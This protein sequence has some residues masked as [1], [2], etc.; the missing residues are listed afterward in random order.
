[1]GASALRAGEAVFLKALLKHYGLGE[2]DYDLVISGP[3]RN[4]VSAMTARQIDGTVMIP[5]DSYLL[6]DAGIKR[7]AE[8]SEAV[9]EYEF[10]MLAVTRGWAEANA[11]AL[12]RF[13]RAH[14][15]TV[16]WLYAPANKERAIAVLREQMSL[17]DDYARRTYA[18][19]VEQ[20]Q[21]WARG[22]ETTPGAS[23]RWRRCSWPAARRPR[24]CPAA[25]ATSTSRYLEA[26]KR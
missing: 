18:Q 11:E 23:R 16:S 26:A 13:V 25:T 2:S 8:V 6:E 12:R 5:P 17:E 22:G 20:E 7:L 1:M 21:H 14:V 3:S 4:R 10:Q 24:P 19:W 9:P 15:D